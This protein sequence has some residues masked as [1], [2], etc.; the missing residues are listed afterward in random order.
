VLRGM[1]ARCGPVYRRGGRVQG[2]RL[3]GKLVCN[4]I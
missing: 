3:H 4:D 2:A 1:A